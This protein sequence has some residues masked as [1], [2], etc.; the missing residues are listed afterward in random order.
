MVIPKK[1]SSED[2]VVYVGGFGQ[3][4]DSYLDEI[5]SLA[6]TGRKILYVNPTR[7]IGGE[8]EKSSVHV[9]DTIHN[10]SRALDK[11]LKT[12]GAEQV[13]FIGHSQGAAVITA[14]AAEHPGV[15]R[16]IVLEC[17]TGTLG[18]NDSRERIMGRF[19]ADKIVSLATDTGKIMGESGKRAGTSFTKE[20]FGNYKDIGFRLTQEIPGVATVDIAPLLKEI[21][22]R[23][24]ETEI[25]LMNANIDKVYST[26]GIGETLGD[27]PSEY[28][29]RWAMY[30]SKKASH[31]APVV[32]RSGLL[33]QILE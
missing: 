18:G 31:S 27:N 6:L 19:A 33:R 8:N 30:E 15:A 10:K 2:W 4:K 22:Q 14:Y 1:L 13:D 7:G 32:E 25:V 21:K 11:I 26:E 3:G 24:D 20:V 12:V 5:R 16:R 23:E 29:D 28:I 9:P 17:P